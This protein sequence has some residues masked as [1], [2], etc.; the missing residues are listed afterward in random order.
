MHKGLAATL[1]AA[2]LGISACGGVDRSGTRD[3]FVRDIA[4]IGGT[5]DPDCVD[6][7]FEGYSDDELKNLVD[8]PADPT[9]QELAND[10]VAC[11]DLGG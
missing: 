7:V 3:Q 11:T 4:D 1:A 10:L 9:S 8:D 6:R 5:A 2:V